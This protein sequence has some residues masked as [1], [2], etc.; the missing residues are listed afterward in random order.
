MH[1][2]V[3]VCDVCMYV[4]TCACKYVWLYA[5]MCV[6]DI[7]IHVSIDTCV[8]IYNTVSC[9]C[10]L[11]ACKEFSL[12]ICMRAYEYLCLNV[13]AQCLVLEWV[14]I[15]CHVMYLRDIWIHDCV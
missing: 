7:C 5:Y 6:C 10:N 4:C 13:G 9:T 2:H 1:A 14:V 12:A 15:E 3:Y 8:Y 11:M